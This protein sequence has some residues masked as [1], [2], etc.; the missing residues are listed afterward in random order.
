MDIILRA[1]QKNDAGARGFDRA[2]KE[3]VVLPLA[4]HIVS[5]DID[6]SMAQ[7]LLVSS[8]GN[9]ITIDTESIKDEND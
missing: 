3:L 2:L 8:N 9:N 4:Y 1:G 6:I 5:K 7:R